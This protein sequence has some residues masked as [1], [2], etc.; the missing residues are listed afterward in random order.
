M[1]FNDDHCKS[2][3]EIYLILS[4]WKYLLQQGNKNPWEV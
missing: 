3:A 4:D 2:K 1:P